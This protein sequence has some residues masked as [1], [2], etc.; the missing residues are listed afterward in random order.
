MRETSACN[1]IYV[2]RNVRISGTGART[3]IPVGRGAE[4]PSMPLVGSGLDGYNYLNLRT[5]FRALFDIISS[6]GRSPKELF[7]SDGLGTLRRPSI[8]PT[9]YL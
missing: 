6:S 4:G 8:R 2:L 7:F 5:L 1:I 3:S 9:V